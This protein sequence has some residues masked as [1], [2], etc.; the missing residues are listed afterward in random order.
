MIDLISIHIPKTAGTTFLAILNSNYE[1][2][3][4]AHYEQKNYIYKNISEIEQFKSGLSEEIRV[5]HGHFT[6]RQINDLN[7][8]RSARFITWLRNPVERVISNYSFFQKRISLASEDDG[9]QKRKHETLLD[10]SYL[11]NSRNRMSKFINGLEIDDFFF[12]GITENFNNDIQIL[13]K[14]MN[15]KN[16]EIP[17]LNDN[18]V[19][20]IKL[21]SITEAERNIIQDLNK[22][23]M[24]LYN[25]I[26]KSPRNQQ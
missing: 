1:K 7:D 20:K 10:Y 18:S 4:I 16:L 12:I 22:E 17:L 15:W 9:L 2:S 13:G 3:T 14:M 19:F 24:E 21:P 26:Y 5:I 23:D 11:E 6:Y 8:T 25:R